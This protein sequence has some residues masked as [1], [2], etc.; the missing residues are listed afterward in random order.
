ML[1]KLLLPV[2]EMN[3][4]LVQDKN[5]GEGRG[6][7]KNHR[8]LSA[9]K[10]FHE[11]WLA[12]FPDRM[13]EK[14][15]VG[16]SNICKYTESSATPPLTLQLLGV[17]NTEFFC[18]FRKGFLYPVNISS[19]LFGLMRLIHKNLHIKLQYAPKV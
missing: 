5:K 1:W 7:K 10:S 4:A 2:A 11:S 13:G 3:S 8:L 19:S 18:V 15:A 14:S 17:P 6:K 16:C 12:E 9:K